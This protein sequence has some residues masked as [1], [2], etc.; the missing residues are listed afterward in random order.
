MEGSAAD[1]RTRQQERRERRSA[2]TD[3]DIVLAAGAAL[4]GVRSRTTHELR[5]RL[6][7]SGY[8]HELVDVTIDRLLALGYMDDEAYARAWV[9]GRDR[10][11]PRGAAALRREL[12]RKG[13][14]RE[15]VDAALH[16]RE[17]DQRGTVT[18]GVIDPDDT[19]LGQ[20]SSADHAAA[21][22]LLDRRRSALLRESDPRRRRQRAYAL[23]A[24]NGFDPGVCM[25]V[26]RAYLQDADEVSPG[27]V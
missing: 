13:L 14:G 9:G 2:V 7:K 12:L 22:R 1:R 6:V 20:G 26:T 18:D 11:R 21:V 27:Q 16:E 19:E 3:P 25:D 5:V 10:S 8:P 24:R 23:L 17:Q 4:L 15:L